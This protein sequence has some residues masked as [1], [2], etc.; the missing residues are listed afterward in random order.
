MAIKLID[1]KSLWDQF[2]D[3]SPQSFLFHKW[4]FLKLIEKYTAYKL[5]PYGIYKGEEL[6][7]IIPLF[8]RR[9]M[10]VKLL[11]SPPPQ[12]GV[13]YLGFI[14]NGTYPN[15]KQDRKESY[16]KLVAEELDREIKRIAPN[17]TSI[18]FTPGFIDLRAFKWLK[19]E[20][21]THYTYTVD[22]KQD[23]E[24]I[25]EVTTTVCRQNIRKGQSKNYELIRSYNPSPLIE[26]LQ[27]RYIEQ[28]M[29]YLVNQ[30]YLRELL[31][32]FPDNICLHYLCLND[33]IMA[34][35][36]NQKFNHYFLAWIGLPKARDSKNPYA[37]DVMTWMLIQN[38]K[39][40]GFTTYEICGA[41][42]S[43]LCRFRTKFNPDLELWFELRKQD[44]IGK[45]AEKA[46]FKFIKRR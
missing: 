46:Y 19:Y 5:L 37:N 6:I 22:L 17:Y 35:A 20:L 45:M 40:K 4:D 11:F 9:I 16:L 14:M 31:Q 13:P 38:A 42:V 36:L 7:C 12:S 33:E 18:S 41:N 1:E 39:Q 27:E 29:D 10:G 24:Q 23:L 8:Y 26:L 25:W 21:K 15:L 32:I 28:G 44:L 34:G 3:N 2:V 43:H 30:R